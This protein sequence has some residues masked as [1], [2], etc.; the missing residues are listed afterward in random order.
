MI[1]MNRQYA[2]TC[3]TLAL[4]SHAALAQALPRPELVDLSLQELADIEVTTVSKRAEPLS[5][6]AASIFVISND[7]IRRS[8]ATTLPEA[9]R[10][11]PNLQVAR[12]NARNYA[13]SAR[14]FNGVFANKMLVLIDGRSV[15]SPL[16]SGVFWDA[17][18]VV[19]EDVDRIEVISGANTTLWGANAVNGVINITTRS[20]HASQGSLAVLRAASVELVA[21]DVT[22]YAD[23]EYVGPL[24]LTAHCVPGAV[25]VV[26]P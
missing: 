6:A 2:G 7:D 16:F 21:E 24:P 15:Y 23:G 11:A 14:G 26:G 13:I 1:R 20:A 22:G 3:L 17:Q 4:L 10:L 19:L 8:G 18:D 25:R 9:L 5:K 12:D